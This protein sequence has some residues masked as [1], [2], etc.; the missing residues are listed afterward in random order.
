MPGAV[1]RT[2]EERSAE[3]R[4]RVLDAA[5]TVL[6]EHGYADTTTTLVA[7]RAGVSRGAQLHHFPTRQ[8]LV[9]AAVQHLFADL[10]ASYERAFEALGP[11]SVGVEVA[12]DLLWTSFEDPRLAVVLD[13]FVAARTDPELRAS[14]G[15]V[16][17]AHRNNAMRLARAYFPDAAGL[18]A[19]EALLGVVLDA[20]QGAALRALVFPGDPTVAATVATVKQLAHTLLPQAPKPRRSAR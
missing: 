16:A 13:L 1:R 8:S 20:L 7:T 9:S 15:P 18:P 11:A 12:I 4:R 5:L 3:M 2:Q 19:F 17:A 6:A 10:T 14:L